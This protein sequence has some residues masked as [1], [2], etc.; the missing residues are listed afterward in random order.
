MI[1]LLTVY[2]GFLQLFVPNIFGAGLPGSFIF[3]IHVGAL[4]CIA[5]ILGL[6]SSKNPKNQWRIGCHM[7]FSIIGCCRSVIVLFFFQ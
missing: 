6:V 7:F 5:G 3:V 1:G 2:F 4:I